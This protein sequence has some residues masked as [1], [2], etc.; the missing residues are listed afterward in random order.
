MQV[1][2]FFD[3]GW[4]LVGGGRKSAILRGKLPWWFRCPLRPLPCP[5]PGQIS[6]PYQSLC[7]LCLAPSPGKSLLLAQVRSPSALPYPRANLYSLPKSVRHLPCSV[8]PCKCFGL[9]RHGGCAFPAPSPCVCVCAVR[10]LLLFWAWLYRANYAQ[11]GKCVCF[12]R[13]RRSCL[14]MRAPAI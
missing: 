13:S 8:K 11:R 2:L 1:A 6:T 5:I 4:R 14:L 3:A 7:T 9:I 12:V 10:A